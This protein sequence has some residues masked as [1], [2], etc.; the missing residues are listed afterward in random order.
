MLVI[1]VR[2]ISENG[3]HSAEREAARLI[4]MLKSLAKASSHV[5]KSSL[6]VYTMSS[7]AKDFDDKLRSCIYT[8]LIRVIIRLA[9]H[10]AY[11][12]RKIAT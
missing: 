3:S 6:T 1:N 12:A 8:K 2:S 5:T 9:S 7:S 11:M 4:V 10:S